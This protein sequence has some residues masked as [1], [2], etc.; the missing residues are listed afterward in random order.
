ML[1]KNASAYRASLIWLVMAPIEFL[2]SPEKA[3]LRLAMMPTFTIVDMNV[4]R[5]ITHDWSASKCGW[6]PFDGFTAKAW[7]VGTIIRGRR[8]MWQGELIG[9]AGGIPMRFDET[10]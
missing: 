4:T 3:V 6:T 5:D 9:K 10:L 8:V 2:V 1:S 7:P